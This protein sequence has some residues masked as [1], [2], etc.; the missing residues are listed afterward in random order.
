MKTLVT[1][2]EDWE[3]Q[4][5]KKLMEQH[6]VFF[7]DEPLNKELADK[8]SDVEIICPFIYSSLQAQDLQRL[9]ELKLIA[10]RSTGFDHIDS[11][12]CTKNQITVCN[13]PSYGKNTVAE[14][15]F[16]L[17]LTISHNLREALD[18]TRRG[19]FSISGLQGFD[20]RN[21]TLGVIGTGDIGQCVITIAKG[22]GMRVLAF[23]ANPDRDTAQQA[24]FSYVDMEELLETSDIITLH[25]PAN[26]QTRHMIS[27]DQ[28]SRMR[29]G[30]VLINTSR[31]SIVDVE[32]L[33]HA[34]SEGR[35]LAAGLDVLPEEPTIRE[36][37]ELLR[38][39]YQ[40]EHDQRTLLA[41]HVLLRLNNVYIT[42]HS[43]FN[44][45]EAVQRILNTSVDNI[46]GFIAGSPQ[47]VVVN[48]S[49]Q[50]SS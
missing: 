19:D 23:D 17:I 48:H 16:G 42:P 13:V 25:V 49:A 46:T 36:E 12:Y 29:K 45:R 8:Y 40:E 50:R 28:F 31:G 6:E 14:H 3:K 20:L 7:V 32:A 21:K 43:A 34:L 47:N 2:A 37:A 18:R 4:S 27:T 33:L 24:A 15:V 9:S 11:D 38:T 35:L 41:D 39:L 5:F 22:F 30:A 1:E 44:T 26:K 10:T